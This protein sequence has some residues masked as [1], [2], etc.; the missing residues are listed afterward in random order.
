MVTKKALIKHKATMNKAT[1]VFHKLAQTTG[2]KLHWYGPTHPKAKAIR[3]EFASLGR[4]ISSAYPVATDTS[5]KAITLMGYKGK[6][7]TADV[8]KKTGRGVKADTMSIRRASS[9]LYGVADKRGYSYH[10]MGK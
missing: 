10:A 3:S 6:G 5:R 2:S 4:T 8:V 9:Y 7:R 1:Y